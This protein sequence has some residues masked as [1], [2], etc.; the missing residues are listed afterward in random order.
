MTVSITIDMSIAE[1]ILAPAGSTTFQMDISFGP[2]AVQRKPAELIYYRSSLV[3]RG[4]HSSK[5]ALEVPRTITIKITST[6]TMPF[7]LKNSC[8]TGSLQL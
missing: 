6:I 2:V 5:N 7:W 3:T 4:R 1:L 8:V